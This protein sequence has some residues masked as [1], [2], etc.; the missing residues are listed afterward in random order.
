MESRVGK[1]VRGVCE[2]RGDSDG[3]QAGK[4]YQEVKRRID[5]MLTC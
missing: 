1:V 3:C 2:G 4:G 5:A